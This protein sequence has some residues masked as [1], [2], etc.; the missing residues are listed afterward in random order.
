MLADVFIQREIESCE[1]RMEIS[2]VLA[3]LNHRTPKCDIENMIWEVRSRCFPGQWMMDTCLRD[4]K[5][6]SVPNGYHM[7]SSLMR[8]PLFEVV[9]R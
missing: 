2:D 6:D 7:V 5:L 4:K 8:S 9:A 3:K 1:I